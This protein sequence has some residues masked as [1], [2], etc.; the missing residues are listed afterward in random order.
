MKD[1]KFCGVQN[2]SVLIPY[3]DLQILMDSANKIEQISSQY[4][5]MQERYVAMQEMFR[6]CLEKL[7]EIN[8][9]L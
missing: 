3:K 6:Q 2:Y 4:Q 9:M 8:R 7:G 1:E 5:E